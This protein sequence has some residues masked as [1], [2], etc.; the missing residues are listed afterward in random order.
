MKPGFCR[1]SGFL[2]LSVM[3]SMTPDQIIEP[4]HCDEWE[5][6]IPE[7]GTGAWSLIPLSVSGPQPTQISTL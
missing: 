2:R 1:G 7:M 4:T 6:G 5:Y 3:A